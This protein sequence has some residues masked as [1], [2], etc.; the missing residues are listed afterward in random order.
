MLNAV[1]EELSGVDAERSSAGWLFDFDGELRT[2]RWKPDT[3]VSDAGDRYEVRISPAALR[4]MRAWARTSQRLHGPVLETG[5]LIFGEVSESAGVVWVTEAEGPPPDSNA[6]E[7]HFTCG[8]EG[9]T[10]ANAE[11]EA[12]FRGSV[13]C[14]GSWH[15]HPTSPAEPS[16]VDIG[17][18]A[19][20]LGDADSNRRTCLL[21]IL[22]GSP[23]EPIVGAHAFRVLLRTERTLAF[24]VRAAAT[25]RI[26]RAKPQV[27]DVGLAL[28]G[29]GSRAI[30]FHLG[31]FRSL[32]DLGL[33][34]R[35]QVISSVS[36]GSVLAAMYAYSDDSFASF[37]ARVV[38]LLRRGLVCDIARSWLTPLSL[39]KNA[40]SIAANV[41]VSLLRTGARLLPT[42]LATLLAKYALFDPRQPPPRRYFSR[43]EAFRAAF[44]ARLFGERRI[45]DVQRHGLDVIINATELRTG[46]AFRFGSQESGCWRFGTIPDQEAFVS[47]AVAATAA[48]PVFLP[49]LDRE[50]TF[51]GRDGTTHRDRV[52][53]T[54]GG[55][56]ENLGVS[57]MEPGRS[58][59]ISTNV[60]TP[61]V[62]IACD[63]GAGLLDEDSFPMW[64]PT[65]MQRSFL[66]TFRKAQDATRKRL[67][68]LAAAGE[69]SGFVLSYLG[70]NDGALPWRPADLPPR[71]QA[72]RYPTGFSPMSDADST[73]LSARGERLTRLLLAYYLPDL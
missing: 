49:A 4:E 61:D 30:A 58:K 25:K 53:L 66:A 57:P 60:F 64:W 10:A 8:V 35:L 67:H 54:D 15:T 33:L 2:Y 22:S 38:D 43:S 17:A 11:K 19:Q 62:I 32:N 13:S 16:K 27:R 50:Y 20:L 63:A 24:D 26:A 6:S 37:D 44:A 36:G 18:V 69:I 45:A 31:C 59:S 68:E 29:G 41:P 65:R 1:A 70:Q 42:T 47:D 46:S 52:L 34:D 5:G 14:L 23:D 28:S 72:Y 48:Y 12:R 39:A 56:F 21:L 55:V 73:L 9:M 51:R 3:V 71:D 40:A 7:H